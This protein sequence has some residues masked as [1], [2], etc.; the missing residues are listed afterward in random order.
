M[1]T[2]RKI[3]KR[4]VDALAYAQDGPQRQVLWDTQIPGFGIRVYASG[5]KSFVLHYNLR[6]DN[7]RRLYTIGRY[8]D[9]TVDE[10]RSEAGR[11]RAGIAQGID[12][13]DALEAQQ[14][15]R[16]A[17]RAAPTVADL[18]EVYLKRHARPHK[19]SWQEDERRLNQYIL[20]AFGSRKL[21]ELKRAEVTR[22]HVKIGDQKPH[23]ANRVL[24]TLRVMINLA[25]DWGLMDEDAP[26]PATRV[27]MFKTRSRE[28]WVKPDE[29]PRLVDAIDQEPSEYVR[30]AI[31]L[32][33]LTGLRRNELLS[34]RWRD[35]DF[36][37]R[38]LHLPDSKSGRS[39]IEPLSAPAVEILRSLPRQIGNAFVFPGDKPGRPMVNI[40]K[41]WLRIRARFW[42]TGNPDKAAAL[43]EQAEQDIAGRSK[44]ASKSAD[45][46]EARFLALA[47]DAAKADG[48]DLRLH[49]LRRTVGSWLATSGT[50]L[51]LIG[52]VLN[53]KSA[54]ATQIYA[55]LADDAVRAALED[56]GAR[57]GPLLLRTES[58]G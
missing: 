3:T 21:S 38:E 32:Y 22:L 27:K 35:I 49:D 40:N 57:I 48:E 41:P 7:R 26:N 11:L 10:A 45:A 34:L 51:P 23:E 47:S 33:L 30:A 1:A 14:E 46:V 17:E 20:P 29:M 5:A 16:E 31:K 4:V 44:H 50:S 24:E 56:H 37:R 6:G 15:E 12:P 28:R 19:R 39:H 18:A 58:E 54:T 9:L 13:L 53:H 8:G 55:R 36:N 43:R 2:K 52:A 42:A 25:R